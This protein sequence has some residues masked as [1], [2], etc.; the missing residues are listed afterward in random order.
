MPERFRNVIAGRGVLERARVIAEMTGRE[1]WLRYLG[2]GGDATPKD[3]DAYLAGRLEPT[4][5]EYNIL[6]D[7][8]NERFMELGFRS[9]VQYAA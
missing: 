5:R 6:V 7:A 8:L 1:L 3:V 9:P 4:R 2:L